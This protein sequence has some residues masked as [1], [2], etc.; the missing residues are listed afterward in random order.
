MAK[1]N[2]IGEIGWEVDYVEIQAQFDALD[3]FEDLEIDLSTP[4]GSVF[5]G[6]KISNMIRNHKGKVTLEISS[7]AASNN[8]QYRQGQ[9]LHLPGHHDRI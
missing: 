5:Q 8:S 3:P 7:L 9:R 6:V 4:G 2:I 1:I